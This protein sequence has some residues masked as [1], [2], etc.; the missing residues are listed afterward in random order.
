MFYKFL[1]KTHDFREEYCCVYRDIEDARDGYLPQFNSS[2]EDIKK[3]EKARKK[4]EKKIKKF[5][6][7]KDLT[8]YSQLLSY[9]GKSDFIGEIFNYDYIPRYDYLFAFAYIVRDGDYKKA[10]EWHNQIDNYYDFQDY[11]NVVKT[12][13][14]E[15]KK[16]KSKFSYYER[17]LKEHYH[18][19]ESHGYYLDDDHREKEAYTVVKDWKGNE[20]MNLILGGKYQEYDKEDYEKTLLKC[21]S[22]E[23]L[24]SILAYAQNLC[25]GSYNTC[26]YDNSRNWPFDSKYYKD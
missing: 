18:P 3:F 10:V 2:Q 8:A 9:E 11:N 23:K 16:D 7:C 1:D 20:V 25:Y 4:M 15:V 22:W 6:K 14:E 17:L 24:T 19:S 5:F 12:A 26:R 21:E 13:Y